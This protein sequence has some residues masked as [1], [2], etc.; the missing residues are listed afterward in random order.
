M[1]GT[2]APTAK[3]RLRTIKKWCKW[4]IIPCFLL[5]IAVYA[6]GREGATDLQYNYNTIP[7]QYLPGL[8]GM[9]IIQI[10]DIHSDHGQLEKAV[11]RIFEEKPD[12]VV[13]TG[14]FINSL[15]RVTR[16]RK[17]IIPLKRL[18]EAFPTYACLGNHDMERLDIVE[19]ILANTDIHL[20]R[21]E[22][23]T[24]HC[25]RLNRDLVIAGVGELLEYDFFPGRCLDLKVDVSTED[26]SLPILLLCH[27]PAARFELGHY[28]WNLMLAGHTHGNQ[29]RNPL[30]RKPLLYRDGDRYTEG[31]LPIEG[32]GI[33]TSRGI[34]SLGGLRYFCPP[35]INILLVE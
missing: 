12:L 20:L 32:A 23:T 30:T 3:N 21:N 25:T 35:E 8:E 29:A 22:R 11:D 15:A 2:T 33:F 31:F 4:A 28:S 24:F 7:A 27:N 26:N 19:R 5:A 9:K 14:D 16:T 1:T 10:S 34:G 6:L 13:I 17:L 18:G